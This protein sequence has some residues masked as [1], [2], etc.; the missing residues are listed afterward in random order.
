MMGPRLDMQDRDG[1]KDMDLQG[2]YREENGTH[3]IGE[4]NP[5]AWIPFKAHVRTY[6]V[7]VW[8]EV[9]DCILWSI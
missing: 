4:I 2:D 1:S 6:W 3:S 8:Q 5:V 9:K 7:P